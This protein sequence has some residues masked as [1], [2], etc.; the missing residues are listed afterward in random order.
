MT[1]AY[2]KFFGLMERDVKV[3]LELGS[4]DGID[5]IRIADH[6]GAEVVTWECNPE[7]LGLCR[8][9]LANREDVELVELAAWSESKILPFFPVVNGNLG[10]SSAFR[11][12]HD[13]PYEKP[14]EQIVIEVE[15]SR[16]D[17]WWEANRAGVPIDLL[18]MDLQG[19]ELEA[20]KG[21]GDLLDSVSYII[22]E[23][24]HQR[25]YHDTPLISDIEAFLVERGFRLVKGLPAN[26]WFGDFLFSK[27]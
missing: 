11:A 19:A 13:Y 15:A 8:A 16:V 9:R 26:S 24:Q 6:F 12:N 25:L 7:A 1:G 17:A 18:A 22:T 14:Y 23:G 10:A 3:A 4:R 27:D 2:R 21:M 20:L 5:A